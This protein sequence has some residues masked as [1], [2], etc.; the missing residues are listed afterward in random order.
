MALSAVSLPP[1]R[2]RLWRAGVVLLVAALA[3][4]PSMV[5]L[6]R[7]T[8]AMERATA[9]ASARSAERRK[10]LRAGVA[11]AQARVERLEARIELAGREL[12]RLRALAGRPLVA[13]APA[14]APRRHRPGD[15]GAVD[16]GGGVGPPV[17]LSD[18][19][20]DRPLGCTP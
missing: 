13:P 7:A 14:A 12:A 17:V 3:V 19:C 16:R 15:R 10:A 6:H 1:V 11:A 18:R 9:G 4:A 2:R 5:A 8:M 20:I